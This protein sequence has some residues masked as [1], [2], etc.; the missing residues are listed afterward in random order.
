MNRF[1]LNIFGLLFFVPNFE[2][3]EELS[4]CIKECL[5]PLARMHMMNSD[6][7]L[8]YDEIC[9]ILEPAAECARRCGPLAHAQFHQLT[10]NFRLHCVEFEEGKPPKKMKEEMQIL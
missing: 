9:A 3:S 6:I 1:L 8:K 4:N 2:A 5:H 10:A 7:Y